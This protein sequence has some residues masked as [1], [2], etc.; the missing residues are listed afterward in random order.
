VIPGERCGSKNI[1]ILIFI[2]VVIAAASLTIGT[3]GSLVVV[4][5][6]YLV[7]E[8]IDLFLIVGLCGT[9]LRSLGDGSRGDRVKSGRVN[10][11]V[12]SNGEG[13]GAEHD[14]GLLGVSTCSIG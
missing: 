9:L 12:L 8:R 6:N 1:V 13:H 10:S 5:R 14:R 7:K 11:L 3:N 4:F 2:I